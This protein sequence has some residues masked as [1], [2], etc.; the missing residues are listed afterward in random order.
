MKNYLSKAVCRKA[1]TQKFH[2]AIRN[3]LV[4]LRD[5]FANY[6]QQ[7]FPSLYCIDLFIEEIWRAKVDLWSLCQNFKIELRVKFSL[8]SVNEFNDLYSFHSII[9][10][11]HVD[12]KWF[13]ILK[14]QDLTILVPEASLKEK[15]VKSKRFLTKVNFLAAVAH[16]RYDKHCNFYF[17]RKFNLQTFTCVLTTQRSSSNRWKWSMVTTPINLDKSRYCNFR[18]TKA[19]PGIRNHFPTVYGRI[20]YA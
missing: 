8:A 7:Q 12:G 11:V 1:N 6:K 5:I 20:V 16:P 10:T 3:T 2:G 18:V 4:L 9:N 17:N 15:S 19:F 13:N 14:L